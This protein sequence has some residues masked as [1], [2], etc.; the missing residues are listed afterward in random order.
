M[1][2]SEKNILLRLTDLKECFINPAG[3]FPTPTA[4]IELAERREVEKLNERIQ[5][6]L[7][8]GKII[9]AEMHH[10][11]TSGSWFNPE[12]L[13]GPCS[14]TLEIGKMKI[15]ENPSTRSEICVDFSQ[16]KSLKEKFE[17]SSEEKIFLHPSPRTFLRI[18]TKQ[19]LGIPTDLIAQVTIKKEFA[20]YGLEIIGG[21][22]FLKPG[23]I[24]RV[25]LNV[26][27]SGNRPIAL[28]PG[29]PIFQARFELLSSPV[30]IAL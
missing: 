21:T 18:E 16:P 29:L 22:I 8:K 20:R 15:P 5:R 11:I 25:A 28:S 13:L 2:L 3:A 7:N 6:L 19:L 12:K 27:N 1:I 30:D 17:I 9:I 4:A 24:G 26:K 23:F 14:L 10:D